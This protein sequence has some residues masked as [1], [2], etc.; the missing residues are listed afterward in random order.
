[1][2]YDAFFLSCL[3][4]V[5]KPGAAA[6][7]PANNGAFTTSGK[8]PDSGSGRCASAY[9]GGRMAE[10]AA[11]NHHYATTVPAGGRD[12]NQLT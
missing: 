12:F 8:G 10:L 6:R 7:E 5:Q 3:S 9:N 4:V 11:F 1:L 2:G